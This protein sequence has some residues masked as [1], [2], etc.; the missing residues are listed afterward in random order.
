MG[1]SERGKKIIKVLREVPFKKNKR[2]ILVAGLLTSGWGEGRLGYGGHNAS[3]CNLLF[4]EGK[5]LGK[6]PSHV[7]SRNSRKSLYW[8]AEGKRWWGPAGKKALQKGLLRGGD[9]I[10]RWESCSENQKFVWQSG[11]VERK[12]IRKNRR[13]ER[14]GKARRT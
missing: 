12:T 14:R 6:I 10:A 1:H 8:K 5:L 3:E 7:L 4:Q 11:K 2:N 13:Q 9:E